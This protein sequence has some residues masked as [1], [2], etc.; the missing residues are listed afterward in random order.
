MMAVVPSLAPAVADIAELAS[1][2]ASK[3]DYIAVGAVDH[4]CPV[5]VAVAAASAEEE[6]AGTQCVAAVVAPL[7]EPE[8]CW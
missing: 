2:A 6:A 3:I 8:Y 5:A 4:T 7:T 1:S